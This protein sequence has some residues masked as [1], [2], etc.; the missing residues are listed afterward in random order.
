MLRCRKQLRPCSP[1]DGVLAAALVF[2]DRAA[3]AAY[4]KRVFDPVLAA[5]PGVEVLGD[6]AGDVCAA[7]ADGD[8][9]VGRGHDTTPRFA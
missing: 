1:K 4:R 8:E 7:A 9:G 3:L 2:P 5:A 6:D